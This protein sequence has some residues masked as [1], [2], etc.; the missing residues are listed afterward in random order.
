MGLKEL[1]NLVDLLGTV[2]PPKT[3][4]YFAYRV[5]YSDSE[6]LVKTQLDQALSLTWD[7]KEKWLGMIYIGA[8]LE[9][10]SLDRHH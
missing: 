6:R 7:E 1:K 5:G 4:V 8:C 2:Y 3:P 10:K 9:S